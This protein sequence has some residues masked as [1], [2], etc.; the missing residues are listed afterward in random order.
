MRVSAGGGETGE[1]GDR[2][3]A[4]RVEEREEGG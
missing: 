4:G 2:Q 3:K 1:E